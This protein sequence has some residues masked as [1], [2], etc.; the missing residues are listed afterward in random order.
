[1]PKPSNSPFRTP[2][3]KARH[4]SGVNRSTG[5]L[6]SRLLRTPISPPDRS[7]TSTQLP[8]AKLSE[9][10][11]QVSLFVARA[12]R[13]PTVGVPTLSLRSFFSPSPPRFSRPQRRGR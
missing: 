7:A 6:E 11:T 13:L 3:I 8:L 4:S 10:L 12:G 9:L 1:M 5:P 2:P